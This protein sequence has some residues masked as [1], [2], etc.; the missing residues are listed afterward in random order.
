[1]NYLQRVTDDNDK[2]ICLKRYGG[3]EIRLT[4]K[5]LPSTEQN[6]NETYK[7]VKKK[8]KSPL[9]TETKKAT[10]LVFVQ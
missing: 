10:R 8:I 9:H 2:I 7:E 5:Y 3:R 6:R 1:M 4:V